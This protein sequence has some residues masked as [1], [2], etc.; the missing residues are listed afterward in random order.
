[1]TEAN[2]LC[3]AYEDHSIYQQ[4]IYQTVNTTCTLSQGH[5]YILVIVMVTNQLNHLSSPGI[6]KNR[7][8][9]CITQNRAEW[10]QAYGS[11]HLRDQTANT[12]YTPS[13]AVL[14]YFVLRQVYPYFLQTQGPAVEKILVSHTWPSLRGLVYAFLFLQ[15][16]NGWL[17]PDHDE[18]E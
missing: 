10:P 15:L 2:G 8:N 7:I 1:M 6:E 12:I 18:T 11:Q 9:L 3:Q 4:S 5:P 13:Q 17:N 14:F 16:S